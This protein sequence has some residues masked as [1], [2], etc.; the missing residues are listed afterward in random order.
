ML[1]RCSLK[2]VLLSLNHTQNEQRTNLVNIYLITS[3]MVLT[4]HTSVDDHRLYV[5]RAWKTEE[6]AIVVGAGVSFCG[7]GCENWCVF[8]FVNLYCHRFTPPPKKKKKI[9]AQPQGQ[10]TSN[11]SDRFTSSEHVWFSDKRTDQSQHVWFSNKRTDLSQH[12][13][14]PNKSILK[15][16]KSDVI[17]KTSDQLQNVWRPNKRSVCTSDALAK[18]SN[19]WHHVSCH[20]N[21]SWPITVNLTS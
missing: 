5:I 8:F 21:R 13:W 15:K 11:H 17:T 3:F 14:C 1:T 7:C 16:K 6:R 19:Q 20:N 12:V 9:Y 2:I 4:L 10:M 18:T